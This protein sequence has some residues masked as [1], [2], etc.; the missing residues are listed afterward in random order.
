MRNNE[1]QRG[2]QGSVVRGHLSFVS[3]QLLGVVGQGSGD[4]SQG[5]KK[6]PVAGICVPAAGPWDTRRRGGMPRGRARGIPRRRGSV[7]TILRHLYSTIS[8][9]CICFPRVH[10]GRIIH[11]EG[12]S[13]W[14]WRGDGVCKLLGNKEKRFSRWPKKRLW[15]E[16]DFAMH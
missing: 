15:D 2:G 3:G 5:T 8:G 4:G 6:G 12:R 10:R 14:S 7:Y 16:M 1:E 11:D 13:S 9:R